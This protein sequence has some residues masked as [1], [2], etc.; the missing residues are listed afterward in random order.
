MWQEGGMHGR[1]GHA[2][3]VGGV[4]QGACV[5]EE[6]ITAEDVTHPTGIHSC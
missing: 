2:L 1:W 6:T 4:W 3:E 5:V